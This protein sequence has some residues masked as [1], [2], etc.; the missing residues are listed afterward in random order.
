LVIDQLVAALDPDIV[1][2]ESTERA[3]S[4][5]RRTSPHMV[6]VCVAADDPDT[7]QLL[8]MLATDRQT[9]RIPVFIHRTPIAA[10]EES[11][12]FE[13]ADAPDDARA[14]PLAS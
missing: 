14:L 2:I 5:I 9:S 7:C 10:G 3:Y 1:V 13:V 8:S 6:V 4:T 12:A 11:A